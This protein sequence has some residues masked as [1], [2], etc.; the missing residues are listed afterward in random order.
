MVMGLFY[1]NL[2]DVTRDYMVDELKYDQ[3]KGKIYISSRLTPEGEKEWVNLLKEALRNYNDDWLAQELKNRGYIR[4][5]EYTKKGNKSVPNNAYETL[6][7][8]EFNRYYIR[9]VCRRA[10]D[11]GIEE[12]EVYRGKLVEDPR[13]ESQRKIGQ[14]IKAD[15]LLE[16]LRESVGKSPTLGIPQPNSGLTVRLLQKK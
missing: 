16:D 2:D 8:G 14:R 1:E 15:I 11:E 5:R 4:K 6:A 7:E 12:V 10:I 13:P 9:G 3:K